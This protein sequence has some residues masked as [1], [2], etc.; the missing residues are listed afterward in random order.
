MPKI[1]Y[2]M[3][4]LNKRFAV[5]FVFFIF[6]FFVY[7]SQI[8]ASPLE[9]QAEM[10]RGQGLAEQERGQYQSALNFFLKAASMVPENAI[11][12]NDIG[13]NYEQLGQVDRAEQY[14][15]RALKVDKNYLPS[16][17]NLA[18]LYSSIG[19]INKA[20]EFFKERLAKA[21]PNDPWRDKIRAELYRIDPASKANAIK[22]EMEATSRQ[23]AQQAG[24][25][26]KEEFSLSVERADTH[27]KRA[28][29]FQKK[30]KFK[31]A[32][33]EFDQAL[34][35]TPDNPRILK[36]RE[37]ALY[38]ER[39]DEVK[40]RIAVATE[41]LNTGK[42]ESAKKEFQQILAI[43]PEESVQNN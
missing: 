37:R 39:I 18:Y 3:E 27:Y 23:L 38:E 1:D 17:S 16:Y 25:K 9:P 42:V 19:D 10:Y 41:Q 40:H 8:H 20:K 36:A 26:E 30:K 35:I 21:A 32:V 11:L 13:I 12:Y 2:P 24:D 5:Q 4:V 33:D 14:Y 31:A 28:E 6:S 7:N 34:K 22:E 15:L 29:A 43:I